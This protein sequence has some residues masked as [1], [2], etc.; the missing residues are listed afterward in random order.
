[1]L[2]LTTAEGVARRLLVLTEL[3]MHELCLREQR[4]GRVPVGIE[5]IL[6]EIPA[7]LR[8]RLRTAR[9]SASRE[10]SPFANDEV[11]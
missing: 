8:E 4:G 11:T 2:F 9:A 5:F 3:D 6:A 1:M 7:E 10:V